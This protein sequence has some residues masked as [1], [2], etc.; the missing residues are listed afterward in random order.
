M[1]FRNILTKILSLKSYLWVARNFGKKNEKGFHQINIFNVLDLLAKNPTKFIQ[2]GA[3]D[4]QLNDPIYPYIKQG[5]FKGILVE[6][7]PPLFEKLKQT[8]KGIS[9]LVFENVGIADSDGNMGFYFLP[10][11]Y[12]EPDWLQ[13]IGTFDKKAIELNLETLP[14]LLAKVQSTTIPTISLNTLFRRNDIKEVD[15]LIIDAEGF[16]YKILQQLQLV[17]VKPRFIIFEWGCME[18]I[19]YDLLIKLLNN[20][21]YELFQHDGDIV[22]L[23]K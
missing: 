5:K 16:E 10:P 17:S 11:E 9:G 20:Q 6:P 7:L 4:G 2:I 12:N 19:E 14:Q 3:N 1:A 22:A 23:K 18:Q 21:G 8:Y 15:L 13:Q